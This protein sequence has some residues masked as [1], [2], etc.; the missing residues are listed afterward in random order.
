MGNKEYKPLLFT[1]TVRNPARFK[2]YLFVLN[3]FAGRK[4]DDE[5]ATTI[6]GEAMRFGI[7][8][9]NKKTQAIKDSLGSTDAGD[10]GERLLSDDDIAWLLKNNPQR[11]KEAGFAK[12]WPSRFATIFGILKQFGFAYFKSGRNIEISE[13]GKRMVA[14]LK[15]EVS[16]SGII[17]VEDIN[18]KN[19]TDAFLHAMVKYHRDNPFLG[20]LNSNTPLILLL[21]VIKLLKADPQNNDAGI[22]RRELPLLIFWKDN[23]AE[24]VYDM[25]MEIRRKYGY[26][27]SPET[28]REYCID[29]IMGGEFKKFQL[30]SI[31]NE[32]PDEYIRKMRYTGL[33]SLRG[34]GNF[35]DINANENAKVEYILK[36]YSEYKT[37]TSETEYYQYVS[38]VDENL[39]GIPAEPIDAEKSERLLEKWVENYPWETTKKELLKLSS[40]SSSEDPVLK[41]LD[42]PVRLEFLTAIAVKQQRPHYRVR[43]NYVCDDEGLPTSTASGNQGDIE[44][45]GD[46][47]F[48]V[49]VTMAKGRQQVIMEGWPVGRHLEDFSAKNGDSASC[50]FVAPDI[51]PDTRNQFWWTA[52]F[53][54]LH[55][56]SYTIKEFVIEL[57]KHEAKLAEI[58]HDDAVWEALPPVM[59]NK[60]KQAR[61]EGAENKAREMAKGLF[62]DGIPA[63]ILAHRSGLSED[64][65]KA[66]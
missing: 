25:I 21:K 66:L 5:L 12:G 35:I 45:Y 55:T 32:Y 33:I 3:R 29:R 37:Y 53:K 9:P 36:A 50:V 13:I 19:D 61:E 51:Y 65:I 59:Q 60:V 44:C 48:L 10:F 16:D 46:N 30:E 17:D 7:Y 41:F 64:E 18:P 52:A 54:N 57:D 20:V 62:K 58:Q 47:N 23:N 63:N 4:L 26:K 38:A 15:V 28:I 34:A 11:H 27:P 56:A 42:A 40:H 43:P 39:L 49:E 22:S 14:N 6:C 31:V 8:R 24:A 2:R 1:T